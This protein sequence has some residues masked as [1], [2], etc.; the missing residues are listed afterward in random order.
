M[1]KPF[2]SFIV[3]PCGEKFAATT[4]AADRDEAGKIGLP[5]GK[6]DKGESAL[7]G[8]IREANEEGFA[9]F[10]V[11]EKPIHSAIVDGQLVLWFRASFALPLTNYKEKGRISP[12]T[13]SREEIVKSG[14][15]NEFLKNYSF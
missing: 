3:A 6:I 14:Y 1:M 7:Q 11:S 13:V 10:G 9:V 12:I 15:G 8:A 4:R 2:A 5:G